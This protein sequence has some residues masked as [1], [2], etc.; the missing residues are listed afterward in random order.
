MYL[1]MQDKSLCCWL[2]LTIV[3]CCDWCADDDFAFDEKSLGNLSKKHTDVKFTQKN[4]LQLS[5]YSVM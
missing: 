4:H 1:L 3:C 5:D 2:M